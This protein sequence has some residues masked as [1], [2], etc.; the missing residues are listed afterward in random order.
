VEGAAQ[1]TTSGHSPADRH[2]HDDPQEGQN[3]DSSAEEEKDE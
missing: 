1:S 3:G 2:D